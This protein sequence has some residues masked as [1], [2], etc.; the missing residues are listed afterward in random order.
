MKNVS[1][2]YFPLLATVVYSYPV[3]LYE[4]NFPYKRGHSIAHSIFK[5]CVQQRENHFGLSLNTNAR[6]GRS[7]NAYQ[8]DCS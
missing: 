5:S 3:C 7:K 1:P 6:S 8:I 4:T 2:S